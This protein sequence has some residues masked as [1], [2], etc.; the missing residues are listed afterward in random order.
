MSLI[1]VTGLRKK[2]IESWFHKKRPR[3]S[4]RPVPVAMPMPSFPPPLVAQT[5]LVPVD[6]SLAR[7]VTIAA[8]TLRQLRMLLESGAV[9]ADTAETHMLS[10]DALVVGTLLVKLQDESMQS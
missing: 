8:T 2:Q 6:Y 7:L 3:Q 1:R 4:S 10:E 9:P 5:A